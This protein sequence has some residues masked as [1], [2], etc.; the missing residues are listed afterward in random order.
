MPEYY[1]D[2]YASS[3][4]AF[5]EAAAA[6]GFSLTSIEH[7][8][9]GPDGTALTIDMALKRRGATKRALVVSSGTH[10]VEG[11]FGSAVQVEALTT[12]L[13]RFEPEEG[14]AVV[15][16]HG[17]NPWGFAHKR[18]VDQDGIDLN[19]NFV[20]D[21]GSWDTCPE[22]YHQLNDLLNP[23]SAPGGLDLFLPRAGVQLLKHG[24]S[25]LKEAVAQGQYVYPKGV[26]FGG[27][28]P[29]ASNRILRDLLPPLLGAC[30]RVVHL[31]LHTG[32]GPW[33][34]YVLAVDMPSDHPRVRQLRREFGDV[35]QA[36][37]P[38]GVLYTINGALGGWL[39][40]LMPDVT[41]DCMLAEFGTYN[42]IKVITE[43]RYENRAVQHA[44]AGH[45]SREEGRRRL[46]E[47]FCPANEDW[48]RQS[49]ASGCRIVR[50]GMAAV[51]Q[52]T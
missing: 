34:T 32:S 30:E 21:G 1:F 45:P 49:S 28:G 23:T 4:R 22:G 6:A 17:V 37:D 7:G 25:S 31:D 52:G 16:L 15:L 3:R 48:R 51:F 8:T 11:Y 38:G 50:Q 33:N 29:S 39:Q 14:Q 40:S 36:F 44:P 13:A 27:R 46:F 2:D 9:K 18:R 47:V 26:F 10:G 35:M 20:P 42:N 5:R 24:F 12:D 19:R 43:L 41:Y